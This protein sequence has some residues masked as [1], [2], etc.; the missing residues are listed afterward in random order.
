MLQSIAQL[1]G[2]NKKSNGAQSQNFDEF[3]G[4]SKNQLK[5]IAGGNDSGGGSGSGGSGSGSGGSGGGTP[6]P[7]VNTD[8]HSGG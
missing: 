1:F 6:V 3:S 4:L 7:P 2:T 8:P 5:H